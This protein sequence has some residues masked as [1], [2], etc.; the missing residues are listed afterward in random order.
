[1]KTLSFEIES[2][3]LDGIK[4][5]A[6]ARGMEFLEYCISMVTLELDAKVCLDKLRSLQKAGK[7]E[8]SNANDALEV[9]SQWVAQAA[10]LFR[11]TR[12]IGKTVKQRVAGIEEIVR[13]LK[14]L[15]RSL[16]DETGNPQ[17]GLVLDKE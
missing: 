6:D 3:K 10:P 5:M 12:D 11:L 9:A 15:M 4:K 7:P 13:E 1:M 8:E 17:L 14:I 16:R 2:E